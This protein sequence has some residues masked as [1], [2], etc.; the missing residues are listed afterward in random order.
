MS[1]PDGWS[2]EG[3]D[4]S[5]G[6]FGH[7][8]T[9]EACSYPVDTV[10]EETVREWR[11]GDNLHSLVVLTC[12]ACAAATAVEDVDYIGPDEDEAA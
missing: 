8:W 7:S 3:P 10:H 9:H 11:V 1:I 4:E 12:S 6:I 2:Y 5:V